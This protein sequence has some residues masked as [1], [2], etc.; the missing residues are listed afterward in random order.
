MTFSVWADEEWL[1]KYAMKE[2]EDDVKDDVE[3]VEKKIVKNNPKVPKRN[4]VVYQ[5]VNFLSHCVCRWRYTKF[6]LL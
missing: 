4:I 3:L 5:L 6:F 1:K 2:E